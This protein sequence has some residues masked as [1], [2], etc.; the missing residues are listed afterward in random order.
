MFAFLRGIVATKGLG[1]IALDVHGAG[2]AVFVPDTVYRK[3]A[4]D[5]EATLLTYCHIREDLFQ[6]YGFLKE[7]ERALFLMLLSINK[8]GPKVAL[9]VLSAMTPAE[10]GRAVMDNDVK[11]FSKVPGVGKAM[12]QRI[13]LEMKSKL[14]Q[15][16]ELDAILGKTPRE[17]EAPEGDDVY[18]ALIALGC[19]PQEAKKASTHARTL[20][21]PDAPDEELVRAA[22][23]SM[24]RTK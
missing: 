14:G 9:S 2:Y 18:E 7:E 12:A 19:T 21:G 24:A 1:Q 22:L 4:V 13:V 5:Q 8:V 6:I 10:F 3:L 15:D 23:R 11:A 16:P 20:L 17:D